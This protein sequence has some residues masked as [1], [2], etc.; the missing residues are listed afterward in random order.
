MSDRHIDQ[1]SDAMAHAGIV[2]NDPIIDDGQLH[3]IHVEGHR[4][5]TKNCAYVLH[6]DGRAAGW[7]MDFVSGVSG[8][9]KQAGGNWQMDANTRRMIEADKARRKAETDERH[10]RKA[11][12][13]WRLY[14]QSDAATCGHPYLRRKGVKAHHGLRV[15]TWRKWHQ[16]EQGQ[17][18]EIVIPGTLLV[19][20][21]HPETG[22][23]VNVQGIF[24]EPH[25]LLGRDKDFLGGQKSGC[26]FPIGAPTPTIL[27]AEGLATAASLHEHTGHQTV[28]AFD[29]G[30]L[31]AV[32]LAVRKLQPDAKIIVCADND[33]FT[34]GNPGLSKGR[35]AAMA[36]KALL[37]IPPFGE[38]EPGSDWNDWYR[39]REAHA[40]G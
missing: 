1:F 6:G 36:A 21:I 11:A 30:N 17:W 13:A 29:A 2:T 34:P 24:P 8:T 35:E 31:K 26:A 9:W 37:S 5:G 33:R 38:D 3:R 40:H 7:F 23:L 4:R 32:A 12:E 28:V 16:D 14:S 39:N 18:R 25:P 15:G 10:Q 27:L 19:P 22:K 20:L